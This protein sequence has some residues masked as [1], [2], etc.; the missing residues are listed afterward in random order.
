MK[1]LHLPAWIENN[2][3]NLIA[4]FAAAV[5]AFFFLVN[6]PIHIWRLDET[7]VDSSVFKTIALMMDKGYMPY[8]DTFDHK[9]PLLYIINYLGLK[10]SYYRGVWLFEAI[11]MTIT[12]FILYKIARLRTKRFSSVLVALTAMSLLFEFFEGGN[13]TEEYAMPFIGISI[14]IFLDYLLNNRISWY[15]IAISGISMGAVC[16]LRP[17]MIAVWIV[18]CAA[19]FFQ[20]IFEKNWNQLGQFVLWFLIGFS[21]MVIPFVI[22]LAANGAL[23]SCID[24]YILF[25]MRYASAD[26][27]FGNPVAKWN[28]FCTYASGTV[29][30]IAFI[31]I[32]YY[33]KKISF[34]NVTYAIYMIAGLIFVSMGGEIRPHYAMVLVPAV[35]YPLSLIM[36]D[37]ENL[38]NQQIANVIKMLIAVYMMT[39]VIIPSAIETIKS[40]PAH[41]ADRKHDQFDETTVEVCKTVSNL[42]SE[43]DAISVYGNWDLIYVITRRK[44]ATLYSYQSPICKVMPEI[45][46]EYWEQLS[47]E[48]PSVIVVSGFYKDDHILE[49]LQQN[50][51]KKVWPDYV[52]DEEIAATNSHLVF[53]LP[54][55]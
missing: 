13:L 14:Y 15:R 47:N 7:E 12:L 17:N 24:D 36:E 50:G 26:E 11:F 33:L 39:F 10:I 41:Y 28:S 40:I 30:L 4:L 19:I 34:L 38:S 18:F 6:S 45:M 31:G 22:W 53:Y 49:F 37:I 20:K 3:E 29:Y 42:T 25:N 1:K 44:H 5:L 32:V 51:Y 23:Q 48:L 46:E 8:K 55:D 43:D 27:G 54:Q 2:K 16:L 9:G 52:S 21:V 35:V